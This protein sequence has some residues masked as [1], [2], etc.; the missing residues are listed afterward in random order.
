MFT[1][2]I[3]WLDERIRIRS[4][5]KVIEERSIPGGTSWFYVLGSSLLFIFILQMLTGIFLALYY[6]PSPDHAYAS[7]KFIQEEATF[8][9]FVRG[10]HH[11][12]ASFM[13]VIIAFHMLRVFIFGSYKKPREIVWLIGVGLIAVVFGFAFTGYLLP[14]DQKAYWA[15][16]VGTN[17]AGTVPVAGGILLNIVRGGPEI[18][19]LT[20][21]RFFA[22]HT[23]ILPWTIALLAGLHVLM[24]ELAGPGGAWDPA[25]H[26]P[27][28]NEPL[29]PNQIYKDS[30][31]ILGIFVAM[32]ALAIIAPAALEPQA[33]PTDTSYNPRPEW[34]FYFMFQLLRV[35]EGPFEVVGTVVLPTLAGLVLVLLPFLDRRAERAPA[36]RKI[37]MAVAGCIV[38]G[39]IVLTMLGALAPMVQAPA[40]TAPSVL[41]GRMLYDKN[42]C[43]A[44]HSID[45]RGGK[46]GPDLSHVGRKRDRDWLIK[47]FRDPQALVPGSIMPKVLLPESELNQLTDYMLSLK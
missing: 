3:D 39:V 9:S 44:C 26:T 6:V 27:D 5:W 35:F 16:V 1:P 13:M 45:G 24:L 28:R 33:D 36:K 47:H 42:G 4:F 46:I 31:F 32:A 41:A 15:T 43:S 34:Y 12:G 25:K 7:V 18:G 2:I 10:M 11:W 22:V 21:S 23:Y 20:L 17:V 38:V 19:N 8:G 40:V 29:F 37:L 14:W 30:L